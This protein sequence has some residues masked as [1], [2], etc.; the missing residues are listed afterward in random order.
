MYFL[1]SNN[2]SFSLSFSAFISSLFFFT[3]SKYS[4]LLDAC[5]PKSLAFNDAIFFLCSSINL[6]FSSFSFLSASLR[7]L[8][9]VA[10]SFPSNSAFLISK[11]F[12]SFVR[13]RC[14][15][16]D[17]IFLSIAFV[18]ASCALTASSLTELF[19]IFNAATAPAITPTIKNKGFNNIVLPKL[20][21][22]DPRFFNP[23]NTS[24]KVMDLEIT[25]ICSIFSLAPA[26]S[27]FCKSP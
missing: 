14:F 1:V 13:S 10:M 20:T 3:S 27:R 17:S 15:V 11:S 8:P 12:I 2:N 26:K 22:A 16:I 6:K 24:L 23:P 25:A 5:T 18:C 7:I 19:Q 21:N 4:S 9:I